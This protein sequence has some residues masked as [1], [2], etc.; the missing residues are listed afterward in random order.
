M[1]RQMLSL[2][3]RRYVWE[4]TQNKIRGSSWNHT[5]RV[6]VVNCIDSKNTRLCRFYEVESYPTIRLFNAN[7]EKDDLGMTI[8]KASSEV[9]QEKIIQFLIDL[10]KKNLGAPNWVNLLPYSSKI[11][12][13]FRNVPQLVKSAVLIVEKNDSLVGSHSILDLGLYE[14]IYVRKIDAGSP[15][16][17][18]I[19]I[20]DIP[21][22]VV[23]DRE[24]NKNHV[25]KGNATTREEI[26]SMIMKEFGIVK[27]E[28]SKNIS[29]EKDSS[30]K[31]PKGINNGTDQ[32]YMVDIEN[33]LSNSLLNEVAVKKN[34]TGVRYQALVNYIDILIRYL[35][36]RPQVLNFLKNFQ[37]HLKKHSYITGEQLVNVI[38]DLQS[39]TS[40]LPEKQ[41]WK[42]CL[43]SKPTFRG[44]PCGLWV[45]FHTL[46][47]NAV[48][49]EKDN[50]DYNPKDVIR[51]IHGY[52][53]YFFTCDY[54]STHFQE[55]Y[56][57]D[58]E[59]FVQ[60]PDDEI[61]WFWTSHNKV[62][63]RLKNSA[64]EDP[65]HPKQL[66]PTKKNCPTCYLSHDNSFHRE[67]VKLYLKKLYNS[68]SI[69]YDGVQALA[70]I[71]D[72]KSTSGS[73]DK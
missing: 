33:A 28:P 3:D 26:T 35:P 58:A 47:V 22:V 6:G 8:K 50:P 15:A 63:M 27:E 36:T 65:Y 21:A 68:T 11:E 52:V 64:S 19:E 31:P 45:T 10:Q 67:N 72:G 41:Q 5:I 30:G 55:M 73:A 51:G 7:L 49:R 70:S 54:C 61:M 17:D 44:F 13:I 60:K 2:D 18:Y 24:T 12:S 29:P 53:K 37:N 69:S 23:I 20:L 38:R 16:L 40:V 9:L 42:G 56:K 59:T 1:S 39:T 32:V 62:N 57:K 46:T 43:G 48:F 4:V 66:F 14:T 34:I 25:L 71:E